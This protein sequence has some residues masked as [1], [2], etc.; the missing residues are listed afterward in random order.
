MTSSGSPRREGVT[1]SRQRLAQAR[2]GHQLARVVQVWEGGH[3]MQKVL[4]ANRGEIARRVIRACKGLGL[5]TVAIYSDADASLPFVREADEAVRIGPAPVAQSYLQAQAIVAAAKQAGADAVH[6]GYGL[7]SENAD[8]AR[9]C[10]E[11]KL[12]FVGPSSAVIA[13]MGSKVEARRF[14]RASGVPIVPGSEGA[15]SSSEE[16]LSLARAFGYP[17]MLKASAGGGGIGMTV[18]HN[19]DELRQA[20]ESSSK[21]VA[22]YFGDGTLYLERYIERPRH[23]EI[24]VLADGQGGVVSLG[25]REC[26]IQRRHQKIVEESPSTGVDA[27]LRA[28]ISECAVRL[29]RALNYSG[30]GTVE[31]MVADGR[32]YF[33][34]MNTRLQVEHPVTEEVTGVDI[35]QWQLRIAAGEKLS[36]DLSEIRAHGHAIECRICA[37]DPERMLPSPGLI[38]GLTLPHGQGVRHEIGVAEGDSVTPYYDPM[39]AKLVVSGPTRAVAIE[40]MQAALGQYKVEGI[41]TN[42]PLLLKVIAHPAFSAGET[43]TGFLAQ[44][45]TGTG[46]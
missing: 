39:F 22:S 23:I 46:V 4:I 6:P 33:L 3:S 32:F 16:A 17:V 41:K 37:E 27:M 35:V 13:R 31:F 44:Y 45:I 25:E 10:E 34:E 30:A 5:R 36:S 29:T 40:R 9:L 15:V 8:F 1:S 12:T 42:I 28:E 21:R 43:H 26:S 14:A 2:R 11:A 7:L 18:T 38:T 20:Y 19:E 24:Q